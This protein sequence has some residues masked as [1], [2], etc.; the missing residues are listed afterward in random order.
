MYCTHFKALFLNNYGS[1]SKD[2]KSLTAVIEID[3]QLLKP[4]EITQ[5][6]DFDIASFLGLCFTH[7]MIIVRKT[8]MQ[9]LKN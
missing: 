4:Y 8:D 3:T 1:R 5:K 6:E 2:L 9:S 7:H